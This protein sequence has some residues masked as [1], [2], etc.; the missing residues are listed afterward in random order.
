MTAVL[1]TNLSA[2]LPFI[3]QARESVWSSGGKILKGI[4]FF[5]HHGRCFQALVTIQMESHDMQDVKWQT[6]YRFNFSSCIHM[7][8]T[9]NKMSPGGNL[10][11]AAWRDVT[12]SGRH[13]AFSSLSLFYKLITSNVHIKPQL[14]D[15]CK[16]FVRSTKWDVRLW[17]ENMWKQKSLHN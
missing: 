5:T 2:M 11:T 15:L 10:Q 7:S 3:F 1:I 14:S 4:T 12:H 13:A 6:F 17:A 8:Q 16:R 9:Y